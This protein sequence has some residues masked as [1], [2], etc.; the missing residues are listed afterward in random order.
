MVF[1]GQKIAA[2]SDSDGYQRVWDKA[3]KANAKIIGWRKEIPKG[4]A[5]QSGWKTGGHIL[6]PGTATSDSIP[7]M[8]SNGE[9]VINAASVKAIGTP[10]LDKINK[11]AAGGLATRYD[12][13]MQSS[14]P[15]M[16]FAEGGLANSSSS[17]YNINVTLNGSNVDAND[18]ATAIA[19]QMKLRDAMNGRGRNN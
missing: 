2:W 18:V 5:L 16:G 7:A 9:Y 3:T 10:M 13:P 1:N 6:G 11:M 17:L 4:F 12:I 19:T 15:R 14:M 8:L